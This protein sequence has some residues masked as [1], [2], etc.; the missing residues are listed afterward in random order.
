MTMN[1]IQEF[2]ATNHEATILWLD[3]VK[4]IVK[5]M[6]FDPLQIGMN[7]LKGMTLCDVNTVSKEG[8]LSYF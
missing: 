8:T 2:D 3:H 1:S 4:A 5:K 7:K 6:G